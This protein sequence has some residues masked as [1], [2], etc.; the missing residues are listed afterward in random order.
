MA[1][2][3]CPKCKKQI[4]GIPD[5]CPH[6]GY[7]IKQALLNAQKKA[8][9]GQTAQAAPKKK[10]KQGQSTLGI[11]ALIFSIIP[12]TLIVGLILSIIDLCRS[13]GKKKTCSII[14]LVISVL[15]ILIIIVAVVA[16]GG[17]SGSNGGSTSSKGSSKNNTTEYKQIYSD[18]N[19]I[20]KY[21][22]YSGT[23]DDYDFDFEIENLSDSNLT[24]QVRDVVIN[25]YT[26]STGLG[27]SCSIDVVAGTKAKDDMSVDRY[28]DETLPTMSELNSVKLKFNIFDT[29]NWNF[30]YE[31]NVITLK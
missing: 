30:D 24:I 7:P 26:A 25:G 16:G 19:V 2:Y 11:L 31:T 8:Q 28:F 17:S 3:L 20:I 9:A 14:G 1:N 10:V 6:C 13:N 22:G 23:E 18:E 27:L 4:T 15:W 29:D 12:C 5:K 21:G